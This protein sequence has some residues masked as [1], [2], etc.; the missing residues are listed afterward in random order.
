MGFGLITILDL[1]LH[2][3]W[4]RPFPITITSHHHWPHPLIIFS[5]RM[6]F[7]LITPSSSL[8][9]PTVTASD[10]ASAITS[11]NSCDGYGL[12]PSHPS[13]TVWRL[14][15][16]PRKMHHTWSAS[17]FY[18]LDQLIILVIYHHISLASS[19][20]RLSPASAIHRHISLASSIDR[21][22]SAS[23]I[24]HLIPLVSWIDYHRLRPFIVTYL[25]SHPLT[26]FHRLQL[27]I[28]M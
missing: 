1:R 17:S 26:E 28:I 16:S 22:S 4:L 8:A 5:H 14:R 12:I 7:G 27:F 18:I 2:P 3:L 11:I 15:L 13:P 6:G 24:Y 21:I 23:D 20:D 10:K 25:W 9:S 19:T